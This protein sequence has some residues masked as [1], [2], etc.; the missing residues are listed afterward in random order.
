MDTTCPRCQYIRIPSDK[1]PSWQCPNCGAAYNESAQPRD[2]APP[3]PNAADAFRQKEEEYRPLNRKLYAGI[4]LSGCLLIYASFQKNALES[5]DKMLPQLA[6]APVQT[7]HKRPESFSFDY[8]GIQYQ[9]N[10]VADYELW[11]LV[12][13]HN[14]IDGISDIYHDE[15][16]VDTKDLCVI[17]GDNLFT[18]DYQAP[19]YSSGA[20]TCYFQYDHGTTF[21]SDQLSNNHMITDDESLREALAKVQIGDQVRFKG[22][23]VNYQDQRHPEFWRTSSTT[24]SDSGNHACEVVFVRELDILREGNPLWRTIY[25]I[26][27]KLLLVFLIAKTVVFF[28]E[29]FA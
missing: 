11:G 27:W 18:G 21:F 29:I 28:K 1:G 15:T 4:L 13:S 20:W 9:V 7:N 17:W 22:Q 3:N 12:V 8:M 2:T 10:T 16:S 14:D 24:R 19:T 23:L 25:G 26:S 5:V 6:Q